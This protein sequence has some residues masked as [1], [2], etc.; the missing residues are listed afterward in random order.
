MSKRGSI[1]EDPLVAVGHFLSFLSPPVPEP[2][3]RPLRER[4]ARRRRTIKLLYGLG[5]ASPG[6]AN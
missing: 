1:A 4:D 6:L 5:I 2:P 3:V